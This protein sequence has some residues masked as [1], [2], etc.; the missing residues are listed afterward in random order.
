MRDYQMFINGEWV[1]AEA[2][3]RFDVLNPATAEVI[4]TAPAAGA[5]DVHRAVVAA[6]AAFDDGPW[7][8]T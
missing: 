5:A 6:R 3:R 4:A 7:R 1:D 2:G 8:G